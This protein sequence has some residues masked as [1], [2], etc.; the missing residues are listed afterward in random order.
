VIRFW[1]NYDKVDDELRQW[2]EQIYHHL[3]SRG[4]RFVDEYCKPDSQLPELHFSDS[5]ELRAFSKFDG[6]HSQIYLTAG[7]ILRI[8]SLMLYVVASQLIVPEYGDI[9]VGQIWCVLDH[10][11]AETNLAYPHLK[12][13]LKYP[14]TI[15]MPGCKT[16][17]S[18][19]EYLATLA[20]E[21]I[22]LHELQHHTNGHL[23]LL[24]SINGTPHAELDESAEIPSGKLSNIDW[25]T[26][27]WDADSCAFFDMLVEAHRS[28]PALHSTRAEGFRAAYFATSFACL[29]MS[30]VLFLEYDNFVSSRMRHPPLLARVQSMT[31]LA[32]QRSLTPDLTEALVLAAIDEINDALGLAYAVIGVPTFEVPDNEDDWD[33]VP[34]RMASDFIDHWQQDLRSRLLPFA[35]RKKLPD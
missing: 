25:R 34:L 15:A 26:L 8:R 32:L 31:T 7:L 22:Y 16:R 14:S 29:T 19:A 13:V 18:Y 9:S 27:E 11:D 10:D 3:N 12:T 20:L 6:E 33:D 24:R 2:L 4:S 23:G 35:S 28:I 5:S 17:R 30:S 21:F 1:E